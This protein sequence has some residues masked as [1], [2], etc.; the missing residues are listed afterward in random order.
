[1]AKQAYALD[2]KSSGLNHHMG[3][4]PIESTDIPRRG[5]YGSKEYWKEH[6]NWLKHRGIVYCKRCE[7]AID[8]ER[9]KPKWDE[10]SSYGSTKYVECPECQA[11]NILEVIEDH[12][13]NI[14]DYRFYTYK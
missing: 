1:M 12:Y 3:S 8:T 9:V 4:N 6:S 5:F 2:S 11:I 13:D 7:R 14:N 10:N